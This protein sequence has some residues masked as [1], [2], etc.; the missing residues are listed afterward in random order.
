MSPISLPFLQDLSSH[1]MQMQC[2]RDDKSDWIT[3]AQ[4]Q[5]LVS[6]FSLNFDQPG[7][8][9][10]LYIT[11]EI[12]SVAAFLGALAANQSVAIIDPNI[13]P[14]RND[15]LLKSFEPDYIYDNERGLS[16]AK[17]LKKYPSLKQ[18]TILL[19]TSG[20]TGSAKFARLKLTSLETN[21]LDIANVTDIVKSDI[22]CAHLPIH[23]SF[24]LSVVTSHLIKKSKIRLTTQG[25]YDANF[26][27]LINSDKINFLPGVPYHF[28]II[29]RFGFE[30]AGIDKLSK[31]AQAG[32]SL[33]I[34]CRR[35]AHNFMTSLA[36]KFFVM[37]GQTE[38]GP[39]ITTL[40]HEEFDE[41]PN[42]VGRALPSGELHI[43]NPDPNGLGEILFS[44]DNVMMSYA[45]AREH[46]YLGDILRGRLNTG[47]IGYLDPKRRLTIVGRNNRYAKVCGLRINLDEIQDCLNH[48][49][50]TAVIEKNEFIKIYFVT[51]D[52]KMTISKNIEIVKTILLREFSIPLASYKFVGIDSLPKTSTGKVDYQSLEDL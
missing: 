33:D 32:G 20:S 29:E 13:K 27:S 39:R 3:Y 50:E 15:Y 12:E 30:K 23:Y 31:L 11:N 4:F 9:V 43:K 42:T 24:G 52:P 34:P 46:L 38:A 17:N 40:S 19:S 36:G 47:D 2:I 8:L 45:H 21:A 14:D 22:A 51:S 16:R 5:E 10:F 25:F 18:P 44:G 1:D 37:Y 28:K 48:Y 7:R 49:Q 6:Q 35:K 26:W 41:A